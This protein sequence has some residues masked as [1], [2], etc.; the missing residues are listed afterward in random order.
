VL[1]SIIH[2]AVHQGYTLGES[3]QGGAYA[4]STRALGKLA[5]NGFLND[6]LLWLDTALVEDVMMSMLV[7]AAGMQLFGYAADGEVFGV[8]H[9]GLADMP[10]RLLER[11]YGVIHSVRNDARWSEQEVRDFFRTARHATH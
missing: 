4:I 11:G 3:V 1:R 8:V 10:E 5:E 2:R 9:K 7:M 6:P